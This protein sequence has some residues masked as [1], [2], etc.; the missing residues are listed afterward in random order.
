MDCHISSRSAKNGCFDD[1]A[2]SVPE[3]AS[4]SGVLEKVLAIW[5]YLYR[6]YLRALYDLVIYDAVVLDGRRGIFL[7][8]SLDLDELFL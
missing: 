4:K 1:I 5:A 2:R 3:T 7:P 8:K 6:R